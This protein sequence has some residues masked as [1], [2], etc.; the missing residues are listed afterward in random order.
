[1]RVH[2]KPPPVRPRSDSDSRPRE[3]APYRQQSGITTPLPQKLTFGSSSSSLMHLPTEN[4]GGFGVAKFPEGLGRRGGGWGAGIGLSRRGTVVETKRATPQEPRERG[5]QSFSCSGG[6][7][8]S[9]GFA[10]RAAHL[11]TCARARVRGGGGELPVRVCSCSCCRAAMGRVQASA[12]SGPPK[13]CFCASSV[14]ECGC[15]L[16]NRI[17]TLMTALPDPLYFSFH[18]STMS[19]S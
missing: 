6:A 1:M 14:D 2:S 3:R 5:R 8:A 10:L 16:W 12:A 9:A 15:V 13:G 19:I 17:I 4:K 11:E 7:S 18:Y